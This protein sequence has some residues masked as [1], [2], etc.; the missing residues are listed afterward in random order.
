MRSSL[1]FLSLVAAVACAAPSA[2]AGETAPFAAPPERA[3]PHRLLLTTGLA[4]FGFG[5]SAALYVGATSTRDT[6]RG[7]VVPL[8]GPWIALGAR[9]ACEG[10]ACG[11]EGTYKA[12]LVADGVVEAGGAAQMILAFALRESRTDRTRTIEPPLAWSI[13][14]MRGGAGAIARGFF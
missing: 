10:G 4:T 14:P 6:D 3:G 9:G 12:L 13:G 1:R 2:A 8:A 7:L 11:D 5:W